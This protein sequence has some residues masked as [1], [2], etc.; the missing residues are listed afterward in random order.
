MEVATIRTEQLA[1]IF[2]PSGCWQV[3]PDA[4]T[5]RLPKGAVMPD[6]RSRPA[7]PRLDSDC[8]TM[9]VESGPIGRGSTP[10]CSWIL[11]NDERP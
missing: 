1:R 10:T 3:C 4:F 2:P 6:W 8:R 5:R 11:R 9:M 7:S